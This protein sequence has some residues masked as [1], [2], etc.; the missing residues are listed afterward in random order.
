MKMFPPVPSS[1]PVSICISSPALCAP[2]ASKQD[3]Q[4]EPLNVAGTPAQILPK[5]NA[6][7]PCVF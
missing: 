3:L 2:I 4:S 7:F 5:D 1:L 6:F